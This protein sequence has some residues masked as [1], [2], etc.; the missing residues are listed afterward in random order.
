MSTPLIIGDSIG[1]I[2]QRN[3]AGFDADAVVGRSPARVLAEIRNI[4]AATPEA[5][6]GRD[7]ILSTGASNNLR[8]VELAR[9]QIRILKESNAHVV[10]VGVGDRHDYAAADINGRRAQIAQE[11]GVSFT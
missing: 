4:G 3:S 6:R 11:E 9:E 5:L 10:V 1:L 8:E 7:V 2:V